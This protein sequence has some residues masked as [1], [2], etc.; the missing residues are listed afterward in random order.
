MR[1]DT[2]PLDS[3]RRR[4]KT[5]ALSFLVVVAVAVVGAPRASA[6][7][8]D[9]QALAK[10]YAPVLRLV[11][12]P[13]P[14]GHGEPYEP[15]NVNVLFDEPS[16]ALRGPWNPTD[17][18][19][20]GPSASDLVG[21]YD[22]HLDFPGNA[23]DPGCHYE[24]WA[25]RISQG[26]APT[27]YAHVA[28]EAERPGKLALQY[29]LFYAYNDWNNLH[30]GDWEMIQLVF[31]AEEPEQ[32]LERRPVEVGYSQ[33]EG[34][35]RA[36]W[37][38]EKLD[39]VGVRPVVFPA[40]G[41]HAN[42]FDESLHIGSS[43]EQGV[44]CDDT[45][46]PHVDIDPAV[47]TIP[48]D[49]A[50]AQK[51]FPWIAFE[52]RWGE[53]QQAFFNGPTGPNLK[54]QWAEPIRW[55]EGWRARSYA[56][57]AG[58]VFGT[59]ATD[60]FCGAVGNGS[61]ALVGGL[62][63]PTAVFLAIVVLFALL[64]IAVRRTEWRPPVPLRLGR[65]RTWGQLLSGAGRMYV[66]RAPLFLG[67]GVL[68]IPISIV[69]TVLQSLVLHGFGVIGVSQDSQVAGAAVLIAV[70]IGTAFTILGLALV[71][72]ATAYALIDI[73]AGRTTGPVAAYRRA[74]ARTPSLLGSVAIVAV[75]WVLLTSTAVLTPLAVWLVVRWALVAQVVELEGRRAVDAVH[76][77]AEL[78]RGQWWRVASIVGVGAGVA[79]VAGPFVG[80]LLILLTDW[81]LTVQN[82]IAGIT[83][84]LVMP[85]VAL[86]TSYVYFDLRVRHELADDTR[87][88]VLPAEI[89]LSAR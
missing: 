8:A 61:R 48:S 26:T 15:L 78:V 85:F 3:P 57:P 51:A 56:V 87:P 1:L 62:R 13:E 65:R 64:A 19:K 53:L 40:A 55:S 50:A 4:S 12:Q 83:Y 23:L 58:G 35:E 24:R 89:D 77:S 43:A 80:A 86:A 32:A 31:D 16:V 54:T 76:R 11:E 81:P 10:R 42:F 88:A 67:I 49:S 2:Q 6:G 41:S 5:C 38:D 29:W 28:T 25:S 7:L 45:R 20:I 9:E 74:F 47:I 79:I 17:L 66:Q 69:I 34:A 84:A 30:E 82:L 27:V 63:N 68:L 14:C 21:L 75:V 39:K 18:V 71:Q 37:A 73:D 46:G 44:G 33:H 72:A 70:T 60:F 52:G 59:G 22:Y 36:G